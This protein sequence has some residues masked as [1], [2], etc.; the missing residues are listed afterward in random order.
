MTTEALPPLEGRL[1]DPMQDHFGLIELSE[2][3]FGKAVT[4]AAWYWKNMPKWTQRH[5]CY[6]GSRAR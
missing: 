4:P 6:V 2:T 1:L 5:Y 3:V